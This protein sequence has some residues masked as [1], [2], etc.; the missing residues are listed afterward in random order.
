V[1]TVRYL[2]DDLLR[3]LDVP[4]VVVR[5]GLAALVVAG[6]V[7]LAVSHPIDRIREFSNANDVA[8]SSPGVG[9]NRLITSS[10]SGRYQFWDQAI[11]AFDSDPAIGIGAGNYELWW[12]QH[13][14]IPV[15]TVDA[16]SLYLQTLAEL[17]IIGLLVLL[18]FLGTVL[19]AGWRAVT[20]AR[21]VNQRGDAMAVAFALFLA[22][23]ASAALDWT[24]QLPAAFA[25]VIVM[26]ALI[27]GP[28]CEPIS[29]PAAEPRPRRAPAKRRVRGSQFGLGVATLACAWVAIWVAGDQLVATV[30]LDNSRS[31]LEQGDLDGASQDARNA[32]AIQPWS[33]EAQ[34]QIA[35]VEKERGDLSAATDA[36]RKAIE[37][38]PRDWRPWLVAAE[39]AAAN[40]NREAA[41]LDL[42]SANHLSPK[43]LPVKLAPER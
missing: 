43:P 29:L 11:A 22:G 14:T 26:A 38:A 33:S 6:L 41:Q 34:L 4:R 5:R 21:D 42:N 31:A 10:G 18:G 8:G 16:H 32:A 15:V 17:G 2:A 19:Y 23:L 13:H 9:A 35:L 24:W 20:R 12:N 28:A 1:A 7:A 37:R 25:P 3:R 40:G 39:I 30:Q 36:V 27:T